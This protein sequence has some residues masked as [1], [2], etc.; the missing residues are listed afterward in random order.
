MNL[1]VKVSHSVVSDSFVTPSTVAHQAP[2]SMEFSRQECQ[3]WLPFPSPGDLPNPGI[4]PGSP[5]LQA[6]ALP[7]EPP[8]MPLKKFFFNQ[9]DCWLAD[10]ISILNPILPSHLPGKNTYMAKFWSM[11]YKQKLWDKFCF[12]KQMLLLYHLNWTPHPPAT[13]KKRSNNSHLWDTQLS[14]AAA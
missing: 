4:E 12:S 14:S 2:L 13:S 8:G 1:K 10:P 6:E 5:A 3:S 9:S 7:S 11:R